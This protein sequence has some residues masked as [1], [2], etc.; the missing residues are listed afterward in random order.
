MQKV[1]P[2]LYAIDSKWTPALRALYESLD[3]TELAFYKNYI[4]ATEKMATDSRLFAR[5]YGAVEDL[6]PANK[7]SPVQSRQFVK[8][9]N[10][11]K[12]ALNVLAK[13]LELDSSELL[14]GFIDKALKEGSTLVW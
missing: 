8:W 6:I 1:A 10:Q 11:N 7:L 13:Q 9:A 3:E 2:L 5:T 14:N 4:S 12:G